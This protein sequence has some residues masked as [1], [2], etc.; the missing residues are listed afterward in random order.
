MSICLLII[1]DGREDY[2]DRCLESAARYLPPMEACVMVDDSG[3]ELGFAGAVQA[4]WEAVLASGCEWVFHLESDFVFSEPVPLASMQTILRADGAAQISLQRQAWN[5]REK[6][7]GGI[8]AADPDDFEDRSLV[9]EEG[10]RRVEEYLSH[11]RYFT[12]NPSLYRS[13]LCMRGWPQVEHSEGV[14][15]H[16][17]LADGQRFLI[18]GGRGRAPLCHHIGE[19]RAGHGY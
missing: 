15:T 5:E 13:S 19:E 12:T 10:T 11:R 6:A 14:F 16:Q 18:Y 17:L 2:L 4:G 8:V 7:A 1:D 3:H 9:F